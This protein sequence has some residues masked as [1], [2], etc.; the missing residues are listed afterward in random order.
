MKKLSVTL[1]L[2]AI[3]ASLFSCERDKLDIP[4]GTYA[5]TFTVTYPSG[6]QTGQTTLELDRGRF[7]CSGNPNRIPAGG[8]GTYTVDNGTI[9]FQDE[10]FWTTDFDGNLI[11]NR[12]YNYTIDGKKLNISTV[13][14]GLG[15]YEYDLERQ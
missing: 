2:F 1:T 12:Q 4:K 15:P 5:G 13:R 3:A 7:S 10:N 9:T 6:T 11:L 14:N 8:S